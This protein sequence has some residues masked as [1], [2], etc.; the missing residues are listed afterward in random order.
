MELFK[1]IAVII[2]YAIVAVAG[3]YTFKAILKEDE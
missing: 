1:A 3:W 2:A